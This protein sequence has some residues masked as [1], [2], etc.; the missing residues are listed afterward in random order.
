[1]KKCCISMKG[2][3]FLDQWLSAATRAGPDRW[4]WLLFS[5]LSVE[6]VTLSSFS[7]VSLLP[8]PARGADWRP[9]DQQHRV[10]QHVCP[11]D[12]LHAAR[13]RVV[14]IYQEPVQH[15]RQH[16]CHHQVTLIKALAVW[17]GVRAI[18]E[19]SSASD[20]HVSSSW[21]RHLDD[22]WK[23]RARDGSHRRA[24]NRCYSAFSIPLGAVGLSVQQTDLMFIPID[25]R[26]AESL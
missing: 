23:W 24:F 12:G 1:M 4:T 14:R 20:C 21:L 15:I 26:R 25:S 22:G 5:L 16:H 3:M 17:S 6:T 13:L 18:S 8:V 9:G 11:G 10:H 2:Q 7:Y 19:S